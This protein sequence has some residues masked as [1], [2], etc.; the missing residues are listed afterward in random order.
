MPRIMAG[1]RI[2][3]VAVCMIL[4]ASCSTD[5]RSST[6]SPPLSQTTGRFIAKES[7][8][9]AVR[10]DNPGLGE[11]VNGNP[12]ERKGFEI[13]VANYVA[14]GLGVQRI[15]WYDVF[16]VDRIKVL[17]NG[18]VDMEIAAIAISA[19][20]MDKISFA[21]PYIIS[22]QDIMI[23]PSDAT[24]ITGLSSLKEKKVCST[25][26]STSVERLV[27]EF[28]KRWDVPEHLVRLESVR[29]CITELL[30]GTVD[31]VSSG[32]MILAGYAAEYPDRLLLVNRPFTVDNVGI[33]LASS[34]S[35][36]ADLINKILKNMIDDGTWAKSI[37]KNFGPAAD[38]FLANPPVPGQLKPS[39]SI[40]STGP[41][42]G[43]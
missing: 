2:I 23:R 40:P 5:N 9:I 42:G 15:E 22:G 39:W 19:N 8:R 10:V 1:F 18:E 34:D 35:Q 4:M 20:R 7:L 3:T 21:G 31:A 27:Q 41:A 24:T 43:G 33:G 37:K 32:N 14:H 11:I 12:N 28:G 16:P 29:Q 25:I 26:N 38:L 17:E 36:E 6:T 13:D 30:A